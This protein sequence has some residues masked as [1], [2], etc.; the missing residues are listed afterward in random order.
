MAH[1]GS[2]FLLAASE[3]CW[4]LSGKVGLKWHEKCWSDYT[5]SRKENIWWGFHGLLCSKVCL[6]ADLKR[7]TD[8]ALVATS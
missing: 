4:V 8:P 6:T 3:C 2:S 1:L 7:G 5:V